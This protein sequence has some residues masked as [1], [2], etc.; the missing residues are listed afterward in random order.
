M[1]SNITAPD[2]SA[3]PNILVAPDIA[4]HVIDRAA[5]SGPAAAEKLR[6]RVVNA[7]YT[8]YTWYFVGAFIALVA[9]CQFASY[10]VGRLQRAHPLPPQVASIDESTSTTATTTPKPALRRLPL[11]LLNAYRVLAFRTTLTLPLFNSLYTLNLA[12]LFCT[13]AYITGLYVLEFYNAGNTVTGVRFD[14]TFWGNRA[15]LVAT[16]QLPLVTVLGTKNNVLS[17]ESAFVD[18]GCVD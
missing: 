9:V 5:L 15:G 4:A 10:L 14:A 2:I 18:F 8:H 1:Q 3:A 13:L 16:A 7:A 11:G 17:C 6:H 12:E